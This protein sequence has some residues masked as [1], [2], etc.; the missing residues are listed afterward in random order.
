MTMLL[1]I[2]YFRK[3]YKAKLGHPLY[4][5][6]RKSTNGEDKLKELRAELGL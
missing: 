5:M 2:D 6:E 3:K 4:W 1:R